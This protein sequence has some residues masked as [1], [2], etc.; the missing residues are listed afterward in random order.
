MF[1]SNSHEN[2][3]VCLFH[4]CEEI[5]CNLLEEVR[6]ISFHLDEKKT[7]IYCTI[8]NEHEGEIINY[9]YYTFTELQQIIWPACLL[10]KQLHF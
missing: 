9:F 2:T 4:Y 5:A 1:Q 3:N 8:I 10:A 7:Y 6:I